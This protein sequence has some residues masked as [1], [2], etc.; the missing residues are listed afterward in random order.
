LDLTLSETAIVLGKTPRQVRYLIKTGTLTAKKK[1]GCWVIDNTDL[2]LAPAERQAMARRA[3]VAQQAMAEATAPLQKA[4]TQEPASLVK[5][6]VEG[7][8]EKKTYSVTDLKT[9]TLGAQIHREIES[10]LG[11]EDPARLCLF[12][13][14][15]MLCR[16]CH[17]F[18]P[19]QK[20]ARF[21]EAREAAADAVAFLLLEGDGNDRQRMVLA[22][23]IETEL[24]PKLAALAASQEKRTRKKGRESLRGFFPGSLGE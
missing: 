6:R 2:P 1:N 20:E 23:R 12:D 10:H 7:D 4:A 24:I 14:L 16:G 5:G 13:A 22:E 21:T 15:K 3:E 11:R 18:Q 9:F 19:P 8:K 17:A